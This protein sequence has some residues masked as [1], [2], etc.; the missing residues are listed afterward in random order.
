M[1][2]AYS[3]I[4]W[5]LMSLMSLGSVYVTDFT[6]VTLSTDVLSTRSHERILFEVDFKHKEGW[7]SYWVN[8]GDSGLRTRITW[9]LPDGF[10]AQQTR[11][12]APQ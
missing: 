9:D 5:G 6:Q 1:K 4:I 2:F 10:T 12:P 11:W 8:P 7:H 3:L